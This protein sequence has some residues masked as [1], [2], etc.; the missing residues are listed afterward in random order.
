[1]A[2]QVH[3]TLGIPAPSW[4]QGQGGVPDERTRGRDRVAWCR[5]GGGAGVVA[6]DETRR[7]RPRCADT[8]VASCCAFGGPSHAIVGI[9]A[10]SWIQGQGGVPDEPAAGPGSRRLVSD[11]RRGRSGREGWDLGRHR[12]RCA[13]T[14]VASCCAIGGPSHAIVGI[15]APSWAR[16][17]EACLTSRGAARDRVAWC[18]IGGAAGVVVK[19]GTWGVIGRD[20]RTRR[21]R[22]AARLAGRSDCSS[23]DS[24]LTRI[25]RIRRSIGAS[26]RQ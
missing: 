24:A 3:A 23:R 2:Q 9:P 4:A 26:N 13:D 20:A 5:I 8:P 17:R 6:K 16:D 25:S 22:V 1:M 11:R 21:L 14:P 19:D 15:P 7:H 18:R 12:P 10:P